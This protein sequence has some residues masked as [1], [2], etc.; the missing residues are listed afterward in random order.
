MLEQLEIRKARYEFE[1][2]LFGGMYCFV[3]RFPV[4]I[5]SGEM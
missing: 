3:E 4:A 2:S 1:F 5:F